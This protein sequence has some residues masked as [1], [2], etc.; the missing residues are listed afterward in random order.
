MNIIKPLLVVLLALPFV[1]CT[2]EEAP[3]ET[4]ETPAV[5]T[6]TTTETTDIEA[7]EDK[8]KRV[9][10]P[11]QA[12]GTIAGATITIDYGQPSVKGR[13]IWGDLVPYNKLWR[14][15]ANE[16]TTF[17]TDKDIV[18]GD[19]SV[20]PG[21]YA[22]FTIPSEDSW[23]LILNT[24]WEQWGG[25]DYN[26]SMDVARIT[27]TPEMMTENTEKLTF[28]VNEAVVMKW[29]DLSLTLPVQ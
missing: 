26:D 3:Q 25:Y 22:L 9:S 12:T 29:A 11:A 6:V 19:A 24:E 23:T 7:P 10:P 14:T 4:P 17:M 27:L 13:T 21:K 5:D 28:E 8:S 15:G 16:A 20:P 2:S 1:A 18:I